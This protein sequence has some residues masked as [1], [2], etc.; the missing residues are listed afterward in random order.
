MLKLPLPCN[1][2]RS[3]LSLKHLEQMRDAEKVHFLNEPI[4]QGRLCGDKVEEFLT[5]VLGGE[6]AD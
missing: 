6:E 4:A 2:R 1:Q 3:I 5:T